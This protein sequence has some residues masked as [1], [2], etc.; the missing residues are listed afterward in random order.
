MLKRI[1]SPP[2]ERGQGLV[3]YA[4][5]LTLVSVIVVLI[6]TAFGGTVREFY[7]EITRER[8]P[9]FGTGVPDACDEEEEESGAAPVS[10]VWYVAPLE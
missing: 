5:I 1:F 4:M 2:S 7:C 8:D 6:L 9:Y 10:V 3:E